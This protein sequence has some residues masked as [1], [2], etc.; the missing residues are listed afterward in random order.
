M[1]EEGLE[2]IAISYRWG[3]C[4]EQLLKSPDY[5]AHITSFALNDLKWLCYY[6]TKEPDLKGIQYL[7]IGAISVDQQDQARKTNIILKINQ[8]YEKASYILAV[9]DLHLRETSTQPTNDHPS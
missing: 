4:N 2:Y 8:I 9:P 1:Y 3:E 5:N 7:W 6:I